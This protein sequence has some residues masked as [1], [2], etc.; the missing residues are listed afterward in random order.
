VLRHATRVPCLRFVLGAVVPFGAPAAHGQEAQAACPATGLCLLNV[1]H[2]PDSIVFRV[3]P[4]GSR[5][6]YRTAHTLN[7]TAE[8]ELFSAPIGALAPVKREPSV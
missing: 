7:G 8:D 1:F 6:V 2:R 3:S 4:D 5:V